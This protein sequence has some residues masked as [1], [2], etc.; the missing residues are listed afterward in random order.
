M[1]KH[2]LDKLAVVA[3]LGVYGQR[4]GKDREYDVAFP[5][6]A[7]DLVGDD[8]FIL[9]TL[10]I[11]GFAHGSPPFQ[12]STFPPK[13]PGVIFNAL[14]CN[15]PWGGRT[16]GRHC[17]SARGGCGET[18]G[19]DMAGPKPVRSRF[20]V[21]VH[22]QRCAMQC[23][24]CQESFYVHPPHRDQVTQMPCCLGDV[25]PA[26]LSS[27]T[28]GVLLYRCPYCQVPITST[29]IDR[30]MTEAMDYIMMRRAR[31]QVATMR[32]GGVECRSQQPSQ[33]SRRVHMLPPSS[34]SHKKGTAETTTSFRHPQPPY[35]TID[36]CQSTTRGDT[37]ETT[38]HCPLFHRP[39][40]RARAEKSHSH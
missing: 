16:N 22:K 20:R 10:N 34:V 4:M 39:A 17:Q 21:G 32:R 15:V 12:M 27:A 14:W 37:A 6:E 30:D 13:L 1:S 35:S 25:H 31:Q 11:L 33:D 38:M 28:T 18:Y 9:T 36:E 29:G 3:V 2:I 19:S 23:F 26:C 8:K 7:F 24:I 40:A 5:Q